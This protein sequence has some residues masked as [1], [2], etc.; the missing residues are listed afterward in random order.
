LEIAIIG[1]S[2][3]GKTT[4]FNAVTKG[5]A[6]VASFGGRSNKPNIGTAKVPDSRFVQL[7]KIFKPQKTTPAEIRFIDIPSAPEGLG[8]SN[9]ISGEY[10]NLLQRSDALALIIR[11]F[12]NSSVPHPSGKTN[13]QGDLETMLYELSFA[14]IEIL[15]RRLEKLN[16]QLKSP[17]S[18]M[19]QLLLNE[20][21]ILEQIKS[22]LENGI[23]VREQNLTPEQQQSIKNFAL[24]TN[25]PLMV[26]ININEEQSENTSQTFQEINDLISKPLTKATALAAQLEM[27]L[28]EMEPEDERAFRESL[29]L[30]ESG[31]DQM[32]RLTYDLLNLITFF[33]VGED[34][35]RAWP[36]QTGTVAVNA[37]GEIHSDI[38][39]GFIRGEVIAFNDLVECNGMTDA[40]TKGLIRQEGRSYEMKDG[41]IMHV[42][43]NV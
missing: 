11:A 18:D 12:Q 35:N 22:Q 8:E 34:E 32:V 25:K 31:L 29:S 41:D 5:K 39:K 38:Q 28:T 1:L 21:S 17:K 24:L 23:H 27:E 7:N 3:S 42:L 15:E 4:V 43:F 6:E 30:N 13:P 10:L 16:T 20:K 19:K 36:I 14:D 37:A 40:K 33:T 9:G 26:V 2:Q